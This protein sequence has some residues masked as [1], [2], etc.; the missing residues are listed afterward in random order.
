MR[1]LQHD[2]FSIK[3]K[4]PFS[5]WPQIVHRFLEEQGLRYGK[6][7][8]F[9]NEFSP[10]GCPRAVRDCPGLGEP[11]H[12]H[13]RPYGLADTWVL[14]N[15]H[16]PTAFTEAD[17]LPLMK[18]LHRT[19]GFAEVI[20]YYL[21]VDFF[22]RVVPTERDLTPARDQ[23]RWHNQP[24]DPRIAMNLQLQG[25]GFTL[26]RDILG[27]NTLT[28]TTDILRDGELLDPA[29][30]VEAL[31]ALL[32]GIRHSSIHQLLLSEEEKA[33]IAARNESAVPLLE[34]VRAFFSQR[35]PGNQG[36]N[37]FVSQYKLAPTLK[38][39]AKEYGWTYHFLGGG[40]FGMDKR[41]EKGQS[42]WLT[43]DSGPSRFDTGFSLELRGV[44]YN[45]L[46]WNA[47]Y[48][49]T[50]QEELDAAAAEFFAAV[51]EFES[52]GLLQPLI[53]HFPEVPGWF[54]PDE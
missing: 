34:P 28:M 12:I 48:R 29:P 22:G 42:L 43:A 39:L 44:G 21:D 45:H 50:N 41:T 25:C 36:Q 19:Y 10:K 26:H 2:S 16:T 27:N 3:S 30:Y 49:P 13:G 51:A 9:F 46:L 47:G 11:I 4:P 35:L 8:Y 17:L 33:E 54:L 23:A 52:S 32:P 53:D 20:L 31:K 24:L 5:E 38:K 6:F 37:R 18:K 14:S 40:V 15:I 7:Y 1:L